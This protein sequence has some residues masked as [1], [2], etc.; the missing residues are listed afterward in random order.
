M[1]IYNWLIIALW[2]IFIVFWAVSAIGTKRNIGGTRVWRQIGLRLSI[3]VIVLLA[4]RI[5]VLRHALQLRI[6]ILRH[7]LRLYA[8]NT[9]VPLGLIG[10]VRLA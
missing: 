8:I 7:E 10:F 6:P 9:S 1:T 5:P 4:L 3:F 2:L